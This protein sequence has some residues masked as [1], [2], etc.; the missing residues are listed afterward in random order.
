MKPI[1][2]MLVAGVLASLV[3]VGPGLAAEDETVAASTAEAG[4]GTIYH[5]DVASGDSLGDGLTRQKA[6]ATIQKGIDAAEDGD[7]V[8]VWP[9]VYTQAVSFKGKAITVKSAA[10]SAVLQAP[11]EFAVSFGCGE[12]PNSVLSNFIIRNSRMAAF[13]AGGCPTITNV[14]VVAN[15][16]GIGAYGH[17]QPTISNSIFWNNARGDLF[18]CQARYSCLAGG[19][20]GNIDLNPMF[21]DPNVDDYHLLSQRGRYWP[22]HN[23]WVLDDV[24]SPCVDGGDPSADASGERWPN[25][26]R[27]N[28]GAYGGTAYASMS[29]PAGYADVAR[30]RAAKAADSP[31]N[32]KD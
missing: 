32:A 24:T 14:T 6:F 11:G 18:Q 1:V 16:Y 23:V 28:M 30:H 2:S 13:I 15:E 25:G 3:I 17:C 22:Q 12:G 31:I 21:A 19:G 9:G 5:V 10:D 7:T 4:S 26:G 8:L 20:E 29:E 27:I